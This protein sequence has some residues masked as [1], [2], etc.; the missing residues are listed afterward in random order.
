VTFSAMDAVDYE[1]GKILLGVVR[2]NAGDNDIVAVLSYFCAKMIG[3]TSS[4]DSLV[5][6]VF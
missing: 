6:S 5:L 3:A 2:E 4:E 1:V